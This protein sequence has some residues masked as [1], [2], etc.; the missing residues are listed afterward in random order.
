MDPLVVM[1]PM[2]PAPDGNGLA[3]RAARFVSGASAHFS[4]VVAVVPVAGSQR[5]RTAAEPL[6]PTVIVPIVN[7]GLTQRGGGFVS[8]PRWRGRLSS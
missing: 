5:Y 1:V 7:A 6:A 2:E 3:M 4:V 8:S